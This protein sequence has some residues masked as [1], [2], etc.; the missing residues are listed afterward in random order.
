MYTSRHVSH[1]IES[2]YDDL[3]KSERKIA[4][5]LLENPEAVIQMTASEL[6]KSSE[7]SPASVIRFC[8]SVGIPSFTE[9]K[10]QLSAERTLP[11]TP[12]YSDISPDESVS[13]I[14]SKLLSNAYLS[15]K[16]T[17]HLI[18]DDTIDRAVSLIKA[19]P[20]IYTFG[21]GSSC[22]VAENIAQKWNRIGKISI[23][24]S[25]VHQL[26]AGLSSAPPETVFIGISNSGET[27]EVLSLVS[28][29]QEN[30]LKTMGITQFSPNTLSKK[31]DLV[32]QTVRSKEAEIRSA[33]TS[34]LMTQ[35][36]TVDTLFYAY[37][38][39]DYDTHLDAIQKSREAV[40]QYKNKSKK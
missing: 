30:G 10:L 29:A 2:I 34:S 6:A 9:L 16:E 7:T 11:E 32:L 23:C 24:V 4:R 33:A 39:S 15:M 25:D 27:A 13:E 1:L 18:S 19:A 31:V 38:I 28:V 26:I 14:K 20:L 12:A 22:L 3:P 5:F 36:M 8:R 37:V 40:D 35:F 21:I 17:L